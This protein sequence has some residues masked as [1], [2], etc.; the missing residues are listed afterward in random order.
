MVLVAKR[1]HVI[2]WGEVSEGERN[3]RID[4]SRPWIHERDARATLVD[5]DGARSHPTT[6]RNL[7]QNALND[8]AVNIRQP[9]VA[10]LVEVGQQR[11]IYPHKM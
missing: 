1:R 10:T 7:C 4:S 2:A 11:V 8:V 9:F 6:L 3:P 5:L